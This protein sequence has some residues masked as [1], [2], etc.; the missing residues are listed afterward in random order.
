MKT[1]L[2]S[3]STVPYTSHQMLGPWL[4]L[5]HKIA[6]SNLH[7]LKRPFK[8]TYAVT[9]E[10]HSRCLNCN[11]WKIKPHNE[12]SLAEVEQFAANS[13]FLS[14]VDFTGGEPTDRGDFVDVVKAFMDHCPDLLLIHFPTNGL[15]PQ[16][17][18]D[19][20]RQLLSLKPLQLVISVSIDGPPQLN[21]QLRG[22]PNSFRRAIDTY[23]RIST[24]RGLTAYIGM[25][26][27]PQNR[28]LVSQTIAAIKQLIPGFSL[29]KLHVN[30][31]HASSHYYHNE[32]PPDADQTGVLAVIQ[33]F[34]KERGTPLTPFEWLERAYHKGMVQ[35]LNTKLCPA[36]C[37][38]LS[39]SCFLAQDGTVYP[40]S[41]WNE[42]LG[43]IRQ[44]GYSLAP[45]LDSG[46][47]PQLRKIIHEKRCPNCWTPCEA[48]Q[49][50]LGNIIPLPHLNKSN[51]LEPR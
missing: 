6:L 43:N 5:T 17:I 11:I 1:P 33:E 38:A 16:R 41:I 19:I 10:C 50:I 34:I 22:I 37:V 35:Y 12:L 25:T 49:S 18:F 31:A 14:W 39:A 29:R 27:Y 24:L 48:Y 13:P 8:L 20:C 45:L 4:R 44:H 30:L 23:K 32:L 28:L 47:L 26:W 42:P 21:D 3:P 36:D 7:A 40:C 2:N 51:R 15:Q 46:A 9:Q